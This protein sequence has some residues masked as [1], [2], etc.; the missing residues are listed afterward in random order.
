[1]SEAGFNKVSIAKDEKVF[2]LPTPKDFLW[3][4]INSTPLVAMV[5]NIENEIVNKWSN[6]M[7]NGNLVDQLN[8]IT[9]MAIK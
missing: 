6:F 9:A 8:I 3:Q 2:K 7:E 4:Y 5:S 1:M